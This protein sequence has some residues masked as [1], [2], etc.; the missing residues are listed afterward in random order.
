[1]SEKIGKVVLDSTL[2]EGEDRYSD[3]DAVE[4]Q[5]LEIVQHHSEAELETIAISSGSWPILYHLS[6]LRR[7]LIEWY[8]FEKGA[9]VL[10]LGSG[11]GAITGALLNRGLKVTC[12]DLSKRRST[13]NALRHKEA[14]DL[15]IRIRTMD[16]YLEETQEKFDYVLLLGVFEYASVFTG[17][18][19]AHEELLNKINRVLM[20]GGT[21]FIA[22]ENR[23]GLKYFAG[24]REDHTG[25][26]FDGI[27]GYS[28]P[29]GP[30][31]FSRNELI[32]IAHHNGFSTEFYYPYPD[33]K[34][35]I[36][37]FSDNRLP[38]LGELSRNWHS[39]DS[40]RLNLFNETAAFDS[41]IRAG[42][43]PEFSNSFLVKLTKGG[44]R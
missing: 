35:P 33:Y 11:C 32:N 15:V 34:F 40:P 27:Q 12:V 36:Q 28:N 8:P 39:F 3:G 44:S 31:T 25:V 24:A 4:N 42:L 9:K 10:E 37:I 5:L 38:K 26:F 1:M 2:W 41:I 16:D 14:E 23:L 13:I 7:N 18:I 21:V 17:H 22:I 19:N 20:P 30:K 6:P 43:F 29:L